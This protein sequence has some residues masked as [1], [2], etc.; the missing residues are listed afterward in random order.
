MP[1]SAAS[2]PARGTRATTVPTLVPMDRE[3]KQA[4][5]NNP[6]KRNLAGR[7]DRV[8]FTVASMEPMALAVLANAPASTKIQ[9][10]SKTFL[11]PAPSEKMAMRSRSGS[12]PP[13]VPAAAPVALPTVASVAL[14]VMQ[15]A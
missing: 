12:F 15:I 7:M 2:P 3:M 14:L 5:R 13:H 9:I 10:I 11:S 1:V 6:A 4:A 8:R